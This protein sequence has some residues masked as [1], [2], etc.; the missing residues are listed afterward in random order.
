MPGFNF[1]ELVLILFAT[2]PDYSNGCKTGEDKKLTGVE[3][4]CAPKNI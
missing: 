3:K 2:V 1:F 4:I